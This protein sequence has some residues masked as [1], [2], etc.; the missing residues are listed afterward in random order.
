MPRSSLRGNPHE[1]L[2]DQGL[3]LPKLSCKPLEVFIGSDSVA[4]SCIS[5]E[6]GGRLRC[7]VK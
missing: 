1:S 7:M 3:E 6:G 5:V 4:L 2:P